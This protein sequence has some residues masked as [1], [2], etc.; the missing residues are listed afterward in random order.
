MRRIAVLVLLAA[1]ASTA[2]EAEVAKTQQ[3]AAPWHDQKTAQAEAGRLQ[4]WL[5]NDVSNAGS[6][7]QHHTLLECVL[8][9]STG[10]THV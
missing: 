5:D 7:L 8:P 6:N 10:V 2:A 4:T 9:L 3:A 1:A